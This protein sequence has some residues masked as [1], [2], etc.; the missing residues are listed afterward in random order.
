MKEIKAEL[1]IIKDHC[2]WFH[3]LQLKYPKATFKHV[4]EEEKKFLELLKN[5]S[6]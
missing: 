4:V 3:K 1:K 5:N 6:K 2:N